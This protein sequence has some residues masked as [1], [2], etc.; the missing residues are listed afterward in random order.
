MSVAS[1]ELFKRNKLG[2][3]GKCLVDELGQRILIAIK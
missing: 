1:L 2:E 3:W